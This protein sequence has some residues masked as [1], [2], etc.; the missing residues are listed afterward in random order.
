MKSKIT[1]VILAGG[2]GTR[3]W[4]LSR[5]S[6]PK[7]FSKLIGETSLFQ[8]T[9][10]RLIAADELDFTSPVTLTN[11]DFRFIIAEQLQ[12]VGIDPG[13]I[14]I[15]PEG[16]NTA[17]AILAACLHAHTEDEDAVLLICPSDHHIT[18]V[19]RFHQSVVCGL[20]AVYD[21]QL[22]TFGIEPDR[23]E[24]G[25]G[26]LELDSIDAE[27][28]YTLK[29]FVE[30]PALEVARDMVRSGKFLWNAGIF[31]MRA[32]DMIAAFKLH[33]PKIFVSVNDALEQAE[34]DLGFLRLN[35]DAWSQCEDISIDFAI[36]ERAS[37]LKAVPFAGGWSDLGDWKAIWNAGDPDS[38]GLVLSENATAIECQNVL[39]RSEHSSQ[40]IV[41][42]GLSDII[43]V[44]MQDAVLVAHMDKAQ[45]VKKIVS[46]LKQNNI[47]QSEILPKDHRPW[48]WF[49][50][51]VI[52]GEYQVKRICVNPGGKL[53]L[54]SHK[55]RSEHWIVVNGKARVTV[56]D[57]VE[58]ISEG[59]SV[60]VPQGAIHR[61]ENLEDYPMILIEVQTGSYLG[62][63]D[64]IRYED[65][66]ART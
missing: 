8:Q 31:L 55:Y 34:P 61:M 6:Y 58:L 41:G 30:K 60:Y 18:D 43:A 54:Q 22:V 17:P 56:D 11:S 59:Q 63:D 29:R 16:R 35:A 37:N 24:I 5:K 3:L 38:K 57:N 40:Q 32:K 1:P 20:K 15:E 13:A 25:Y 21:G 36:M 62:E 10:K 49:E 44:A 51:L 19:H 27:G 28:C 64:I 46:T 50:T 33:C 65:V 47:S 4:P 7:Q 45:H 39:L 2:S 53:S 52:D 12:A 9:A 66:Y 42:L 26:Y 48:G 14:L 23:P